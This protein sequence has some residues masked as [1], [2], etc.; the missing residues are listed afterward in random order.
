MKATHFFL[1][2]PIPDNSV[3]KCVS[4]IILCVRVCMH[5]NDKRLY[6]SIFSLQHMYAC[7]DISSVYGRRG[8]R[9][10]P[11]LAAFVN[12][13]AVSINRWKRCVTIVFG[14]PDSFTD[15]IPRTTT[16]LFCTILWYSLLRQPLEVLMR[17][18]N[19]HYLS[20]ENIP[21]PLFLRKL[22]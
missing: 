14:R 10:S 22:H 20:A 6:D 4:N 5:I 15:T 11:T 13:V 18:L 3:F 1:Y 7:D 9:L 2:S 16:K 8:T 17:I 21:W 19:L 12:G